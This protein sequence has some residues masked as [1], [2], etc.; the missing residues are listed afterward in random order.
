MDKN[1]VVD[2]QIC[3]SI[4]FAMQ[5]N[6]VPI[7]RNLIIKNETDKE[8]SELTL[9]ITFEPEFAREFVYK[10]NAI[11]A[12]SFVEICP[13]NIKLSTEFLFSLTEKMVGSI[14]ID[15]YEKD[16]KIYNYEN[17]IELLAYDEWSGLLI[18]PEIITAFVTPNHPKIAEVLSEASKYLNKWTERPS[19]TGYQT[20]NPNNVKMQMA[21][22]Y[23]VLQSSSIIYNNPPAS[24]ESIG[25]RIRLPH[26][27]LEQKQGTCLDLAVTYASCLEA[28]GLFP[29]LVFIKGHAFCGCWLEEQT[30]ADCAVDDISAL[31]KRIVSGSEELL[32]VECTDFTAGQNVDFD[33]A[34]KH[35]K[36][37]LI[38]AEEFDYVIDVQRSRG[39]GIHPIPIRLD[40]NQISQ[41]NSND[42]DTTKTGIF[43]APTTLNIIE[44]ADISDSE[45]TLSRQKIWERKLL[46]FSLRNTLL[47]FRV[48]KN[49]LQLMVADLAEL[50]DKLSDGTDFR[51]MEVPSEW[52]VS[53]RDIKM[54]EIENE[55]DLVQNIAAQEFKNNRIRTFLSAYDL[56][57]N[58][59][60]LYRAAK[61]SI[62][63][64]GT[65]TLFLALGLLK[66]FESDLSEK[67]RY[68][69]IV[70]I[71]IDIVKSPRNK[72]YVIRSRQE[73]IQIN[74]TLIEYLRQIFGL[75]IPS[76]DPLPVD[77][78][79]IDLS[80]VFHTIRQAIMDKRRWNIV[81]MAF[82]GLFS[83]GQFVM[84]NDIRNRSDELE[85]NKVVS[86]LMEKRMNWVSEK[87][88]VSI[89][90]LDK[91]IS[92]DDMAIPLSADSSQMLAIAA[93]SR[94]ESFVLHGPPGTGKSQTITNM[95][96]NAL[97][98]GKSVLFVAEKMAALN[99]VQNRLTGIGLDPFCLELHSNK[100]NKSN[101]LNQ[102]NCALEAG[103]IKSP[104][105]YKATA[106]KLNQLRNNLND[107]I[108][109]LHC[110]RKFGI[111]LYE[112]IEI[113]EDN[114]SLKDAIVFTQDDIVDVNK[115]T[116]SQWN[117]LIR[118]YII[119]AKDIGRYKSHPLKAIRC[120][121]YSIEY[122]DRMQ[123]T[124]K[125]L[126]SDY[127]NAYQSFDYLKNQL[128]AELGEDRLSITQL[129]EISK[130][131][132]DTAP[133][134][135]NLIKSQNFDSI[136]QQLNAVYNDGILYT[137]S[138]NEITDIF[139]SRVFEYDSDNAV[140]RWRQ[141]EASWF[142]SK[143]AQ[144]SK[145][146]KELKIFALNPATVTKVNILKMY[147]KLSYTNSLRKKLDSI[148]DNISKY[149]E[150]IF[151]GSVTDWKSLKSALD[152]AVVIRNILNGF[153]DTMR[154]NIIRSITNGINLE[155]TK[156]STD[157]LNEYLRNLNA[158]EI[159]C[160]VDIKD[161]ETSKTW[162][163][164]LRNMFTGFID[165]LPELRV[166]SLYIQK[167]NI[168]KEAGLEKITAAFESE[169]ITVDKIENAVRCNLYYALI[170]KTI[171]S[172]E[173]LK[174]F[175]GTQ[176]EDT[177]KQYRELIEK[178]RVLTIKELVAKLSSAIPE[179]GTSTSSSSEIGI[180]KRAIKS[181]GRMMSIRK[182]FSE[183]P[184]L[185]R[186]ICP[187]ML[188]SPIS[189]AQY[190][191]PSFPKFDLVIFDEASQLPT[192]EAVGTIA[193]GE[194]VVVVGDPKQLPPT[195]FF[196]SNR[197]DEDNIEN[198][199]LESLLDDCL[200]ISMPQEYLKWH[201]RSRHESLI[202]YSNMQ[203]YGNKL[204]TFPSPN[205][206]VSEVKL[207][208]VE[209]FYDK[210]KTKQNRAEAEAIVNE[211]IRRLKDDN[212]KNDSIGV[213]TF[214]SAQQNLIDD[215][216]SE[217]FSKYP[218][219]EEQD[220]K[221][222][223]PIFIKNLEN[224]QGDERDI[225]L[226]SVGYGPDKDGKVSMNFG[227]LNRDGGWRRLNVAI[228]RARKSMLIYATI[229]PE[230][231]D[232]SRT[233]SDGVAG[234]KGFLEFAA[235]GRNVI[236]AKAN[237]ASN[238]TDSLLLEIAESV[239]KMG[240]DVKCNIGCS[241]YKMDIGVV[242]PN[243]PDTYLLG[244]LLDGENC[245]NASTSK[246]RFVL[247][248]D[249]LSGLGWKLMRVWTLDWFDNQ[250]NVIEKIRVEIENA[251]KNKEKSFKKSITKAVDKIEF[252][253]IDLSISN[254]LQSRKEPYNSYD[255]PINGTADS[256][257]DPC[258]RGLIRKTLVEIINTEAPISKKALFRKLLSSW[259][260][261]RAGNRVDSI[262]NVVI[263]HIDKNETM[264][265][266]N[267][268]YWKKEQNPEEYS[269]YR[270]EDQNG[271]K[272]SIDDISSYEIINAI[273]EVLLEQVSMQ[274]DDLIRET[275]KKFGFSRI[276]KLI[277][278]T[279]RNAVE[280]GI[281]RNILKVSGENKIALY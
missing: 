180:L 239:R 142:L 251:L 270:V 39:S 106:D 225:I 230:Q 113:Y 35:G 70:L 175:H 48:T 73:E 52:T 276:G 18:M 13:V 237:I 174:T 155:K 214:S 79:G 126:L 115:D 279:V 185:L 267:I 203:Y 243:N 162:F 218:N 71:P 146:V 100:T 91:V 280:Q 238:H 23:A 120:A 206:R 140:L 104:E 167:S 183:I 144:Q 43:N 69:P 121:D 68:A 124:V 82:I 278:S 10:I 264:D 158:F 247:Q 139:D 154:D 212:L 221:S 268:F 15:L 51:I 81:N 248:P 165:N 235:R 252:E 109:S 6:Y 61:T 157:R 134:L 262:L 211:I 274:T 44:R 34:L 202:A 83:F 41:N 123:Q 54:F 189:V 88:A 74:I 228:S 55:N 26:I 93:A 47:N 98:H 11:E 216:L 95:I 184:T 32:L 63:E 232:V 156:I 234:L 198:E 151:V 171:S 58:I 172:D 138:C 217:E 80:L 85:K 148:P 271:N 75:K 114:K 222:H 112:A 117:E 193:R 205:D 246:D 244:I 125:S 179:S 224:V 141:A 199:D 77:E 242:N 36:D 14:F 258:S 236:A 150:H 64:N 261:S 92:P 45:E 5:Q 200:S 164:D 118:Q 60:N 78:H 210:G 163:S 143:I 254:T 240:Y 161:S 122:R 19:F 21:A 173:K 145:L 176:Y 166:W 188:M 4:N 194:N 229:T 101:V 159:S 266:D 38:N 152:K 201:Y 62:E 111:S 255:I 187:C 110:Q 136:L 231:I 220:K 133:L 7:I 67:A 209:G 250:E 191:D 97:Y 53:I 269:I 65:N 281:N 137:N 208:H 57:R 219:L 8:L 249:V 128:G 181:N 12:Q 256:F 49:S 87:P 119:A 102:L 27:V 31:E 177:I 245:K 9:K 253:K 127:D 37:H 3:S 135:S 28:A 94:G 96:A 241:E 130:I 215:M 33:R 277:D 86:S 213:V 105:E 129:I 147:E 170:V 160:N 273:S 227:P 20:R 223:E 66:W 56:E 30:F 17:Q 275:A 259:N 76:L 29:L 182:L 46:D 204:Y 116:I 190:I 107:V 25:Q 16:E 195:S 59:K 42:S 207:I 40:R 178:F 153:D 168:L 2:G 1:I 263:F 169:S 84:W 90:N 89:E 265:F 196:T 233:R 103:R 260:I 22:I 257:Y 24:Y 108:G 272:R 131:S 186:K 226:F 72:G 99:V 197:I 50:E 149:A 132:L 192:S